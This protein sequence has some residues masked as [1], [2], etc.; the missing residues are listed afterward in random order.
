[1]RLISL[2]LLMVGAA[3]ADAHLKLDDEER[4]PATGS[5][6]AV[7]LQLQV[8]AAIASRAPATIE[9]SGTY[10]FNRSSL[11]IIGSTSQL[12]LRAAPS[13]VAPGCV[14]ELLFSVWRCGEEPT[15]GPDCSLINFGN[16]THP[17]ACR[18]AAN[19][20]CACS[21]VMWSSGINVSSSAD[22]TIKGVAVD[23]A[24]RSLPGGPCAVPLRP[25]P[26]PPP[27]G[28]PTQQFN[29]GRKFTLNLFNSSRCVVEDLTIRHAPFMAITSFLG[30]GGHVFRRVTFEPDP[31]DPTAMIAGKD[32]LHESDVRHGLQFLDSTIHGTRDGECDNQPS[33]CFFCCT[34]T[35]AWLT[36]MVITRRLFQ[37]PQ[38]AAA[39]VQV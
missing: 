20:S 24:P 9:L 19:V 30:D 10:I 2:L 31:K 5:N 1:M 8:D 17:P 28:T 26:P 3:T 37:F 15:D 32:G 35:F 34:C 6:R 36:L 39:G 29:S 23:Y 11:L 33:I 12:T 18:S 16:P 13:C 27:P 4:N 22:V 21:N 38:H 25:A 14:P 7:Q